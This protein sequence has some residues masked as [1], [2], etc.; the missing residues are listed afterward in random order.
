MVKPLQPVFTQA[1]ADNGELPQV[2]MECQ[3]STGKVIVKYA[4]KNVFVTECGDGFESTLS[5]KGALHSLKPIDTRT[6]KEK[7]IDDILN[8]GYSAGTT[9][10]LLSIAYVKWVGE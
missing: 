7:A 6:D 5:K 1:M 2:G 3:T 8:G 9:R 10:E 4:G